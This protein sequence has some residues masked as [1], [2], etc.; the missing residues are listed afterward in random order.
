MRPARMHAVHT[1]RR[2][3]TPFT[4]TWTLRRFRFQ[5]REVTLWAWEMRLPVRGFFPQIS[6]R[7]DIGEDSLTQERQSRQPGNSPI[8]ILTGVN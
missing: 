8:D 3:W 5:R 4:L 1:R 7:C 6:Q 2:F